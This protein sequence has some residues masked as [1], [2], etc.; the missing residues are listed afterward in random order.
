[1]FNLL[2]VNRI[3]SCSGFVWVFIFFLIVNFKNHG[4]DRG[5]NIFMKCVK[6]EMNPNKQ[7]TDWSQKIAHFVLVVY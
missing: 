6:E 2:S 5:T 7:N 4:F 1:M 3:F